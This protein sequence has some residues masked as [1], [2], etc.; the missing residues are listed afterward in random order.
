MIKMPKHQMLTSGY[1]DLRLSQVVDTCYLKAVSVDTA[2]LRACFDPKI[3]VSMRS[4]TRDSCWR[5]KTQST[6]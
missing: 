3:S 6:S 5:V 1:T 4:V 2:H